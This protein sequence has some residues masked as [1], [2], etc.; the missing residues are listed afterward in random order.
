VHANLDIV[1]AFTIWSPLAPEDLLN[2]QGS[3]ISDDN[4]L[5]E[6]CNSDHQSDAAG[7]LAGSEHD[8]P[9]DTL[10]QEPDTEG[11]KDNTYPVAPQ[12]EDSSSAR[13]ARMAIGEHE[14]YN[15]QRRD[16]CIY[17][18]APFAYTQGLKLAFLFVEN[19]VSKPWINNY[20]TNGIRHLILVCYS[21]LH[22]LEN[23]LQHLDLYRPNLQLFKGHIED[24]K[25]PLLCYYWNVLDCLRYHPCQLAYDDDLGYT[26]WLK[27]NPSGQRIYAEMNRADWGWEVQ[28]RQSP[29]CESLLIDH[30]K[31]TWKR[32]CWF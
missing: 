23:L 21:F 18:W 30:R 20:F 4:K 6:Y 7:D 24:S 27:Y 15:E 17:L 5:R 8:A 16:M 11:Y 14:E 12:Q 26:P 1:L 9:D 25:R 13:E 32:Q 3:D 10:M 2:D 22:Q 29:L 31:G 19:N 28:L